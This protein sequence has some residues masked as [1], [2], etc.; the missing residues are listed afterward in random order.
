MDKIMVN[1]IK[2]NV[3]EYLSCSHLE[4]NVTNIFGDID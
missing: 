1:L 3:H 2:S 4:S